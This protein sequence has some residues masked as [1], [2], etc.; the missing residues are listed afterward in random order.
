[1]AQLRAGTDRSAIHVWQRSYYYQVTGQFFSKHKDSR[2]FVVLIQTL[3]GHLLRSLTLTFLSSDYRPE[4]SDTGP[5]Q[6]GT[7]KMD[8]AC[9]E[10]GKNCIINSD[11][12]TCAILRCRRDYCSTNQCTA[13]EVQ[14]GREAKTHYDDIGCDSHPCVKPPKRSSV[15][16]VGFFLTNR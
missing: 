15:S 6:T 16:N 5:P 8:A 10:A 7:K 11:I 2:K 13:G 4:P 9:E 1:M 12:Q 3:T 14:K